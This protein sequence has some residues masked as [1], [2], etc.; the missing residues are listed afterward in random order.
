M[1]GRFR[2]V[3]ETGSYDYGPAGQAWSDF[4]N[5]ATDGIPDLTKDAISFVLVFIVCLSFR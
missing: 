5:L 1:R 2:A 3:L 4:G